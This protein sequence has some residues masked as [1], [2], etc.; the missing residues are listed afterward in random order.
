MEVLYVYDHCPFCV[1][2]RMIFGF[3]KRPFELRYLLNDDEQTPIGLIGQ[4]M[5]PILQQGEH[6]M[7]ESM[8]IIHKID[9]IDQ[10]PILVGTTNQAITDWLNK[11]SYVNKL[12]IPRYVSYGLPE[13]NTEESRAYFTI[14]KEAVFGNFAELLAETPKWL[15]QINSDLQL[16]EPLIKS[17]T[18]CNGVLSL[19]DIHLFPVLRGLSIV[20][21][22][23]YPKSINDYRQRMSDEAGVPLYNIS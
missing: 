9:H 18:A 23:I 2:A 11:V 16:L 14:K 7:G 5:L 15:E 19:D 4:K 20:K 22:V 12:L 10:N 21:D 1:K 13:F 17:S 6:C 3:K 8:D